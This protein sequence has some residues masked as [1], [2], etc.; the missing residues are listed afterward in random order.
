MENLLHGKRVFV[1]VT[2][3]LVTDQRV[4]RA[5]MTLSE[6]GCHVHLVGRLLPDS[7]PVVRPY[8][9]SRMRLVFKKKAFFYAEY[10]LRLFFKLIFSKSDAFYANDTDTLLAC[11][12]VSLFRNKPL[13]FDAHELFTEV[14]ELVER[15]KV[16]AVWKAIEKWILP[17]VV[18]AV[19][20]SNGVAD[21]YFRR[22]GIR[23]SVVR[24]LPMTSRLPISPVSDGNSNMKTV[25]YQG[26]VN[27]GRGIRWMI[28]AMEYLPDCQFVV[29]GVGDL[30][31]ELVC[32][33]RSKAWCD[34]IVFL[35]RVEP[36]KLRYVTMQAH[37]GLILLENKGLNYYYSFPN[38]IGDYVQACVPVLATAFPELRKIVQQYDLGL[39]VPE[40][41]RDECYPKVVA[42]AV[43]DA[44]T[45]YHWMNVENRMAHFSKARLELCWDAEKNILIDSFCSL[46]NRGDS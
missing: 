16:K 17:K 28:D 36:E 29:A 35:G 41:Q 38:R 10:N 11:F 12:L 39:L 6:C 26:A 4:H 44:L 5:C 34:R 7:L 43:R 24:N 31:D 13:F 33:A 40:P 8:T 45:R 22:Y 46:W 23:M 15:H 14:P 25:L 42:E 19:T 18:A 37:L 21:E 30:Y 9:C 32:Y 3:D 27:E 20:V 1:A 2:N